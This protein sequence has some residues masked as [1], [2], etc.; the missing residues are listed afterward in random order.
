MSERYLEN[1]YSCALSDLWSQWKKPFL[2]P[3][4]IQYID[5]NATLRVFR[6]EHDDMVVW[7]FPYHDILVCLL[8]WMQHAD[9]L[10]RKYLNKFVYNLLVYHVIFFV[11]TFTYE[12][13]EK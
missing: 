9:L 7:L 6:Y 5:C 12:Q 4:H 10:C 3:H 13:D 1:E 8:P 11:S 2:S